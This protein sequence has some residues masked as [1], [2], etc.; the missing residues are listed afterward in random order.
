LIDAHLS[1]NKITGIGRY[2]NGLLTALV[3]QDGVNDYHILIRNDLADHHPLRVL[4]SPNVS[5]IGVDLR[6]VHPVNQILL[7]RLIGRIRPDVYHHPHFDMPLFRGKGSVVTIHDL[8]YIRHPYFFPEFS[9]A[10]RFYMKAIMKRAVLGA[11]CVIAAS[12]NT[13]NDLI[14]IFKVSQDKIDV[15]YH[16]LEKMFVVKGTRGEHASIREKYGIRDK[17]ILFVGERRPHKNLV[18]LMNAFNAVKNN[19]HGTLKLVIIGK[20][21][22]NYVA[23]EERAR[24]LNLKGSVIFLDSVSDDEL[25][26]FYENAELLVLPSHYEGFGFPLIEAMS[27][28]IPVLAGNNTSMPEVVGEAGLLVDSHSSADIAGKIL[29]ILKNEHASRDLVRKGLENI[30]RFTWEKAAKNTLKVYHNIHG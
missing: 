30:K 22:A 23:P 3:E 19:L 7:N 14:D 11:Q 6:G 4:Q 29:N 20:R 2:L 10:K 15:V 16:G 26:E 5:K 28:G 18:T 12:M 21:Y 1:E 9:R 25:G 24:Q 17:F 8:K 27:R 13:K